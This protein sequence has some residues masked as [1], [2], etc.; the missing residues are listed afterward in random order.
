[1]INKGKGNK[2]NKRGRLKTMR[3]Q[4]GR[5]WKKGEGNRMGDVWW[6]KFNLFAQD[7]K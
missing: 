7:M 5:E 4:K 3:Y 1:M 6:E 2:E